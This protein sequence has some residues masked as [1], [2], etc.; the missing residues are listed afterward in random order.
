MAFRLYFGH[1]CGSL[2]V[3]YLIGK[4]N[5]IFDFICLFYTSTP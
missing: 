2:C 3:F 4:R 1:I 5:L